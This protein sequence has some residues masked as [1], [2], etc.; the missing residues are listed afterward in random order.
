VLHHLRSSHRLLMI[1]GRASTTYRSTYFD[2]ADL[3]TARAHIQGRRRRWKARSRL[4]V[5]DQLCRLEVKTKDGRG[6]T[7]KTMVDSHPSRYGTLLPSDSHFIDAVLREG[8]P[9]GELRTLYP[10]AEVTYQRATFADLEASTRVT[11]DWGVT[12]TL[13]SG[14]VWV[15]PGYVLLETKG[16]PRPGIADRVLAEYGVRP[17][18]FSKYVAGVALLESS[19][20]ANDFLALF[21][22]QLHCSHGHHAGPDPATDPDD[23]VVA[24]DAPYLEQER[25]S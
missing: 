10:T 25:A 13:P 20:P 14:R 11:L 8:A 24:A 23:S 21:G 18:S 1:D 22:R 3:E 16:G 7:L 4:Y 5:E 15:D 12:C 19:V 17:N 9:S 6:A 2:T